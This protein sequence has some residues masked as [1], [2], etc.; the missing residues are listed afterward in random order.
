MANSNFPSY[1]Q[2]FGELDTRAADPG[3]TVYSPAAYLADLLQ[4]LEVH[5]GF[6]NATPEDFFVRRSDVELIDLNGENAF[7]TLPY[8]DIVN[9]VL[10][11]KIM[12]EEDAGAEEKQPPYGRLLDT[13]Y[14]FHLPFSLD[15]ARYRTFLSFT[16]ARSHEIYEAYQV[17]QAEAAIVAR[18]YLGLSAVTYQSLISPPSEH[19]SFFQE[20]Y[21]F[22]TDQT[23]G[24]IFDAL[25]PVDAYLKRTNINGESL[26]HL[27][28]QH[29]S[30]TSEPSELSEANQNF[31]NHGTT[32]YAFVPLEEAEISADT[33][34]DTIY[35]GDLPGD[36]S[37]VD[38]SDWFK[39]LKAAALLIRL[40]SATGISIL[41][42]NTILTQCCGHVLDA[43]A[44]NIIA[45]LKYISDTYEMP[46]DKVCVLG[47]LISHTGLGHGQE[48]MDLFN[49]VF[50]V[51]FVSFDKTYLQAGSH[52]HE[53]YAEYSLLASS[54][55]APDILHTDNKD[56][57]KRIQKALSI[58]DSDFYFLVNKLRVTFPEDSSTHPLGENHPTTLT[59]LSLIYRINLLARLMGV[60]FEAF[61]EIMDFL[62][63][64]PALRSFNPFSLLLHFTQHQSETYQIVQGGQAESPFLSPDQV[65]E[66]LWLTQILLA[67]GKWMEAHDLSG[68]DL[69]YMLTGERSSKAKQKLFRSNE[70][71]TRQLLE[72][73]EDLEEKEEQAAEKATIA[74]LNQMHQTF[75]PTLFGPAQLATP[76]LSPRAS[77]SL[78]HSLEEGGGITLVS[79]SRLLHL[80]SDSLTEKVRMAVKNLG[81]FREDDFVGLG[82]AEKLADKLLRNLVIKGYIEPGGRLI[83][84]AFPDKAE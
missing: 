58:S 55:S 22:A 75:V 5:F 41:D 31:I 36:I 64:D 82:L 73:L 7:E 15:D 39:R 9:R 35:W 42:L 60:S 40:S 49:R 83:E 80:Q 81:K 72:E 19:L 4:L 47:G 21:G 14:P 84:S 34:E 70:W 46:I 26:R 57:R 63:H 2:L 27:L 43:R 77:R 29:L 23:T 54:A 67:M 37:Q 50:N 6:N 69:A 10:E 45:T 74:F 16:K 17:G 30:R 78:F 44:L 76:M 66:S 33:P 12:H 8:L 65:D 24:D 52:L 51:P 53:E 56:L 20:Y 32:D 28:F 48:P 13:K 79:D 61:F 11:N 59:G 62:D 3:R 18:E 1:E 71:N 25:R 68:G 38:T